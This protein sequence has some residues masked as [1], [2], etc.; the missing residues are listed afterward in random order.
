[1]AKFEGEPR[2]MSRVPVKWEHLTIPAS[3]WARLGALGDDGWELVAVEG[4]GPVRA[5]YLKR[6]ALEFREMVTLEQRRAYYASVGK[7]V[8][9]DEGTTA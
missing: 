3:E 6:P 4:E 8:P 5:L 9:D 2:T 7:A 1:M